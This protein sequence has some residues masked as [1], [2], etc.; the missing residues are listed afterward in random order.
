MKKHSLLLL[1]FFALLFGKMFS[2]TVY[3]TSTGQHYH[4]ATCKNVN[5][6]SR[7]MQVS[8]ALGHGYTPC[9]TCHP[10]MKAGKSSPKKKT[11]KTSSKKSPAK[12]TK[13]TSK[14]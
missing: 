5:K 10:P 9:S 11:K 6:N 13:P 1:I 3:V 4:T 14:K 12:A 7:S 8:D 2:Q